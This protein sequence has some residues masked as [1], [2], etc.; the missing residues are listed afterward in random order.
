MIGFLATLE[1][2]VFAWFSFKHYERRSGNQ[3]VRR[4][5]KFH[6]NGQTAEGRIAGQCGSQTSFL[7]WQSHFEPDKMRKGDYRI[8]LRTRIL[9]DDTNWMLG[10]ARGDQ[11]PEQKRIGKLKAVATFLWNF[12]LWTQNES[13]LWNDPKP[14][15]VNFRQM[16]KKLGSQAFDIIGNLNLQ[17]NP[18]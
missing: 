4:E 15:F 11:L 8:G 14:F 7:F 17:D 12:G 9:G 16:V 13:F 3:V 10:M 2:T 5:K 1:L 18:R 6:A